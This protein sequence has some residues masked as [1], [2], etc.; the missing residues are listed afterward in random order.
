MKYRLQ[1]RGYNGDTWYSLQKRILFVWFNTDYR[2]E[3]KYQAEK[4]L[5]LLRG[6]K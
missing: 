6:S 2:F 4:E 1:I 3:N 5:K